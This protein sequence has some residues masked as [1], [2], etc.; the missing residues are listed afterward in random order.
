MIT[1]IILNLSHYTSN[2]M[3]HSHEWIAK[4]QLVNMVAHWCQLQMLQPSIKFL[5]KN[6]NF[7]K[8]W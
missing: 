1:R 4:E 5:S 7:I 8:K 2:I 3:Y 6:Y